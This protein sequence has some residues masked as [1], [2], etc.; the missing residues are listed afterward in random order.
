MFVVELVLEDKGIRKQWLAQ[1]LGVHPS[2]LSRQLSGERPWT[3]K[4]KAKASLLLG[5]PENVLFL[6][7]SVADGNG[8]GSSQE[9]EAAA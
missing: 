2:H 8:N 6:P 9:Q 5:V 4:Q 1:Q 7:V 3:A